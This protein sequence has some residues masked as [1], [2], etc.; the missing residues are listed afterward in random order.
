MVKNLPASSGGP[1]SDPGSG[2]AA[3]EGNGCPLQ[4]SCPENSMDRGAW[5]A[6]VHRVAE[7]RTQV[8][9]HTHTMQF[10]TWGF[11]F[12][13]GKSSSLQ[14]FLVIVMNIPFW[15]RIFSEP[16]FHVSI[17]VTPHFYREVINKYSFFSI[18]TSPPHPYAFVW[19]L[20]LFAQKEV[21]PIKTSVLPD[22]PSSC[23]S[24]LSM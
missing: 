19:L 14:K 15:K 2:R 5:W 18:S 3:G 17:S 9:V 16:H 12:Y 6:T 4:Y 22:Q 23:L 11:I 8:S 1:G 20:F 7:S 24:S 13:L 10:L 21:L